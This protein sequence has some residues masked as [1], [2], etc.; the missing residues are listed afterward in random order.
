MFISQFKIR[1]RDCMTQKWHSDITDS[2]HCDTYKEFESLLNVEKHL[3]IDI[4]FYL[5]KAFAGFRCS[6]HKLDIE[7][8]QILSPTL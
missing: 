4:T 7:L 8:L 5:R 1:F 6:S 2:S 3:C